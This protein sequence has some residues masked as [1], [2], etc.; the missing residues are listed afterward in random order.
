MDKRKK[1]I[2]AAVAILLVLVLIGVFFIIKYNNSDKIGKL[3]SYYE[4]IKNSKGYTFYMIV[5]KDN[6]MKYVRENDKAYIDSTYKGRNTKYIIKDGNT[7][8]LK[9]NDKSYYIYDNNELELYRIENQ[10]AN[11]KDNGATK[12]KEEINETNYK[13]EEFKGI[14]NFYF[15]DLDE[16]ANEENIVTRFYFDKDD[17]IVYIKTIIDE[18]T[19]QLVKVEYSNSI[20]EGIFEIPSDYEK[21]N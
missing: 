17:N 1:S 4:K 2:V 8:L 6:I 16:N 3:N 13:Y 10:I 15:G 18:N 19:E 21:M 14:T 11:I 5:N 12:G 9:D 20:E 7:Y